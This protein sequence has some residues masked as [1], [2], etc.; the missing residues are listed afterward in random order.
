MERKKGMKTWKKINCY[1]LT[2]V[3]GCNGIIVV[4]V[5]GYSFKIWI[6]SYWQEKENKKSKKAQYRKSLIVQKEKPLLKAKV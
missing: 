3:D 1:G 5:L 6:L 4:S 2:V